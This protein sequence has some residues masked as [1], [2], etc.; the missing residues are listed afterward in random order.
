MQRKRFIIISGH[1]E[2]RQ[3]HTDDNTNTN[4]ETKIQ[5]NWKLYNTYGE[6]T[7]QQSMVT[8]RSPGKSDIMRGVKW[9]R[10]IVL[11]K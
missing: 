6:L 8:I 5:E 9:Q 7:S 11:F 10:F 2:Q 3:Q 1:D 4:G